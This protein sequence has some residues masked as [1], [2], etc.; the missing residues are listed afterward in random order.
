MDGSENQPYGKG[1]EKRG[2]LR[3]LLKV[4]LINKRVFEKDFFFTSALNISAS[5]VLIESDEIMVYGDKIT[6]T[7]IIQ[8]KIDVTGEVVRAIRKAPDIYH[9]G[10]RFLNLDPKARAQIEDLVKDKR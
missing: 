3:G 4:A 9:Y 2:S 1:V 7:F 10:V 6:C 8:H 5:G